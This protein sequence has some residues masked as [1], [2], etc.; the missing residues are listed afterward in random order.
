MEYTFGQ[1]KVNVMEIREF[2]L[3]NE[4][5][6]V[7]V[8][9]LGGIMKNFI[10]KGKNGRNTDIILGFDN[11]ENYTDEEYLRN[12][13]YFGAVIGRYANRIAGASF[14]IEGETYR[15][16]A[17]E[18]GNTLHGGKEGLDRKYWEVSEHTGDSLVLHCRS[19]DL[20][21]GF[22]GNLDVSVRYSL[23]KNSL[24][25]KYEA[26]SDKTT[27]VNITSHPYFNLSPEKSVTDE[28][29]LHVVPS[30][31]IETDSALIP[32]GK[33]L[34]AEGLHDFRSPERLARAISGGGL[35]TCYVFSDSGKDDMHE[36][37]R[38]EKSVRHMATLHTDEGLSLTV[39]SD[40]P[41]IQIY[42]GKYLNV[43]KGKSG[44]FYGPFS[45]IALEPQMLPDSPHHPDFPSTLLLPGEKYMH[46]TVFTVR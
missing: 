33:I 28:T 41:G 36:N 4:N 38:Y 22:P 15:L 13:P 3:E 10:V 42:T 29:W 11:A 35:D 32:T 1:E 40:Y 31:Y 6:E 30:C 5:I 16:Y 23:E 18:S 46:E 19:I 44:R 21:N 39:S 20:E 26:V 2:I 25:I 37:G 12:Y 34:A 14:E 45:G 43:Q 27:Y 8:L 7:H 24:R 17:N 9:N